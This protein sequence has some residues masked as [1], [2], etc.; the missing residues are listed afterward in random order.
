MTQTLSHENSPKSPLRKIAGWCRAH[1]MVCVTIYIAAVSAFFLAFPR[2]DFLV[3]GLLYSETAGFWAQNDA[4][5]RDVRHLGP[6]LVRVIAISCVAVLVLKLLAPG[7]PPILPLR[8]PLFL[9]TTL[10]MGP[11]VLVN[12]ILKD[13]WG[14]PRPRYVEEFGGDLPHQPVWV[15]SDHCERNCSFVSGEAS[16]AIWLTSVAFL[17]PAS[18]R[19]A[20]L[21]FVL[22]LCVIL[23]ANR[24]AF[25]GHFF[26]DTLISWGVTLLL[27][28]AVYH[29][30][31]QRV[32]PLV[33]DRK[34]DEW[35]TV[36]GRRLHRS[37]RRAGRRAKRLLHGI[38]QRFSEQ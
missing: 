27:I 6:F 26:S 21:C 28:L 20:T 38:L 34:L 15:I 22:P 17:V 10:I 18:W 36:K 30:L 35:F 2:V 11:G 29:L 12:T 13:N 4:F 19:K 1:P 14:R 3:S 31:Y 32:P 23:S 5:L 8:Q 33:T 24:V 9:L 25:G 7:R 16:A 37:L